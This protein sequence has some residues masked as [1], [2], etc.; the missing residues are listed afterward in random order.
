MEVDLHTRLHLQAGFHPNPLDSPAE[1]LPL[2]NTMLPAASRA[3]R[4]VHA[5][6]HAVLTPPGY[7]RLHS[8]LDPAVIGARCSEE[9]WATAAEHA[10]RLGTVGVCNAGLR[11]ASSLGGL[12][13]QTLR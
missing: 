3:W 6:G 12:P 4:L 7:R 13:P 9:D 10:Q 1:D 2:G 8:C 11:L 5:A